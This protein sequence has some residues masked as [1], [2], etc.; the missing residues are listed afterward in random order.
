VFRLPR[1][2]KP[3]LIVAILHERMDLLV[4]LTGRL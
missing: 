2:D 3:A 1:A 4:R